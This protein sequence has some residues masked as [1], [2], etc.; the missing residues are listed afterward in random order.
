M[1]R[2]ST[3][4]LIF[5]VGKTG[6]DSINKTLDHTLGWNSIQTNVTLHNGRLYKNCSRYTPKRTHK[7]FFDDWSTVVDVPLSVIN[8][9][10]ILCDTISKFSFPLSSAAP[11]LI[12][13]LNWQYYVTK[14]DHTEWRPLYL[15]SLLSF[16][17]NYN[18][19]NCF[20]RFLLSKKEFQE[21]SYDA[22]PRQVGETRWTGSGSISLSGNI[23]SQN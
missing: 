23:L 3:Q 7:T 4:N 13:F 14:Y 18:V 20:F 21:K 11:H 1:W 12:V 16:S 17:F 22:W 2:T 5:K 9:V 8:L 6:F 10:R 19:W 15:N